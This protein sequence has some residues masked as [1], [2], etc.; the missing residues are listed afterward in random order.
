VAIFQWVAFYFI[1]KT[2]GNR[3]T[4]KFKTPAA[5][6]QSPEANRQPLFCNEYSIV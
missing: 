4:R 6:S 2:I 3:S 5:R 1:Y